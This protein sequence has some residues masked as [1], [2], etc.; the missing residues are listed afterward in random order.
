MNGV[1]L[2]GAVRFISLVN[3]LIFQLWETTMAWLFFSHP[4]E[5]NIFKDEETKSVNAVH[6]VAHER[7]SGNN[8]L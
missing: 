1:W 2:D 8:L 3:F 4:R 7:V 6:D 5:L